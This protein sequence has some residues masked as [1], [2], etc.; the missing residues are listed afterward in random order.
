MPGDEACRCRDT[1]LNRGLDLG[2]DYTKNAIIKAFED[3]G[4]RQIQGAAEKEQLQRSVSIDPE[5]NIVDPAEE[6]K[7][8]RSSGIY[9]SR[10]TDLGRR[11]SDL[12]IL[13]LAAIKILK[14]FADRFA[15]D[16]S[17]RIPQKD[18][19]IYKPSSWKLQQMQD[20]LR[21]VCE[22]GV[23][24]M[25]ELNSLI[26][27]TGI[28]LSHAK[29]QAS[30]LEQSAATAKAAL[31]RMGDM[32]DT[33]AFVN[34][35]G[36]NTEDLFLYEYGEEEIRHKMAEVNPMRSSQRK[37]LYVELEKASI[38]RTRYRF[39]EITGDEA[40]EAID[41]LKGRI[42]RKPSVLLDLIDDTS[43]RSGGGDRKT[44]DRNDELKKDLLFEEK[45]ASLPPDKHIPLMEAR[46]MLN[47]LLL[48]GISKE[49]RNE[50]EQSLKEILSAYEDIK[51]EYD[52]CRVEYRNL[53]R[54]RY[55][56]TLA[57]KKEYIYGPL[58]RGKEEKVVEELKPYRN[59]DKEPL[60][61]ENACSSVKDP[62]AFRERDKYFERT[63][64]NDM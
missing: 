27:S 1:L 55:N 54:L 41:F 9:I 51:K 25:G 50:K 6:F 19:P 42:D 7:S 24:D 45:L 23:N 5:R 56:L 43:E 34:E 17:T 18:N 26:N 39:E 29:K 63:F 53:V 4:K 28:R 16:D 8:Q 40:K 13:L 62:R 32:D 11:R 48:L 61:R 22:L 38:Y 37:E 20:S 12:E 59:M 35:L 15:V 31:A 3:R 33:L 30:D 44:R 60:T 64:G 52:E 36:L 21:M 47:S 46:D 58:Y 2:E 57:E 14:K 49:N 10:Y